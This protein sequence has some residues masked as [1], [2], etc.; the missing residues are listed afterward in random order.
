MENAK[1]VNNTAID[2]VRV[3]TF[4]NVKAKYEMRKAFV[5]IFG[6]ALFAIVAF[7]SKDGL[8][9]YGAMIIAFVFPFGLYEFFV[10]APME[11][12]IERIGGGLTIEEEIYAD[13]V[14]GLTLKSAVINSNA[15]SM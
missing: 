3:K 1:M 13:T 5:I 4:F 6:L 11:K 10:G 14:P 8:L 15:A 9:G 2:V 7:N 12:E